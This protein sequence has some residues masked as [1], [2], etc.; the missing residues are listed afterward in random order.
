MGKRFLDLMELTSKPNWDDEGAPIITT[1]QWDV[2]KYLA[3][4]IAGEVSDAP[5]VF[6]SACG[7]GEIHLRWATATRSIAVE[8]GVDEMRIVVR[9]E[10]G[11]SVDCG[12]EFNLLRYIRECFAQEQP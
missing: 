10:R 1:E 9:T 3:N 5:E 4:F 11:R 7:D 12:N 6:L 2:A 8:L